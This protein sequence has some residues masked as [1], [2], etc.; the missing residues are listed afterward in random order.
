[1]LGE[2]PCPCAEKVDSALVWLG[3]RDAQVKRYCKS[4]GVGG[5]LV[6]YSLVQGL[7]V[8]W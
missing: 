5:L 4:D 2:V 8:P 1:M 6:E 7:L 3:R